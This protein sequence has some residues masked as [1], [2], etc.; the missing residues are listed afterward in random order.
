MQ[1]HAGGRINLLT[2]SS[3]SLKGRE[4]GGAGLPQRPVIKIDGKPN[5]RGTMR[6]SANPQ[7]H[8]SIEQT[9]RRRTPLKKPPRSPHWLRVHRTTFGEPT[10]L[11]VVEEAKHS[12]EARRGT[13]AGKHTERYLEVQAIKTA[14]NISLSATETA[15]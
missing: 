2:R 7:G 3:G 10:Q 11:A 4:V 8:G 15:L 1:C 12:R 5:C 9:W 13:Q 14:A 6:D